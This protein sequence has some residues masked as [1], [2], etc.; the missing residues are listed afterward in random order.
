MRQLSKTESILFLLGGIL[1]VVGAGCYVFFI[2]QR[3][4]CFLVLAGSVL[5]AAMQAHQS[6]EGTNITLRRLRRIQFFAL[7]CF[8]CAGLFMVEDCYHIL[9][10]WFSHSVSGYTTYVNIFRNNWVVALLIGAMLEMY[11]THRIGYE[12]RKEQP[13]AE[14]EL[15]E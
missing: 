13:N 2:F 8:V 12:A 5:F 3:V 4:V 15:K 14:K 1:M 7:A 9:L 11:T 6:Y 10:P